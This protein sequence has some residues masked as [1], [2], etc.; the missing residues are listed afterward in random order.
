[1]SLYLRTIAT[2]T[3]FNRQVKNESNGKI[4][5][6][7]QEADLC[8]P[9]LKRQKCGCVDFQELPILSG[10]NCWCNTEII[11]EYV[12]RIRFQ[13]VTLGD[14]EVTGWKAESE[15]GHCLWIPDLLRFCVVST[16]RA[17]T[18]PVLEK[19]LGLDVGCWCQILNVMIK[20]WTRKG[21]VS[22][23]ADASYPL[24]LNIRCEAEVRMLQVSQQR[25]L[26]SRENVRLSGNPQRACDWWFWCVDRK[27]SNKEPSGGDVGTERKHNW[28]HVATKRK[29]VRRSR[30]AQKLQNTPQPWTCRLYRKHLKQTGRVEVLTRIKQFNIWRTDFLWVER[31]CSGHSPGN[32]CC[33]HFPV[34][35][36][37]VQSCAFEVSR[38]ALWNASCSSVMAELYKLCAQ[39]TARPLTF[40][41]DCAGSGGLAASQLKVNAHFI[42]HVSISPRKVHAQR[43]NPADREMPFLCGQC[44][45]NARHSTRWLIM[46]YPRIL[47][48]CLY[49]TGGL[50]TPWHPKT[51]LTL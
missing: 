24:R 35:D 29:G 28:N 51:H 32:A 46:F 7:M 27:N 20:T 19:P 22:V 31:K 15:E 16:R 21:D 10:R 50:I 37:T 26:R 6:P 44:F 41:N 17:Q 3:P 14:Q 36:H 30:G 38:C 34:G 43:P 49:P 40:E 4:F 33:L 13:H 1:M 18:L 11:R 8:A 25:V 47:G 45:L 39:P 23:I 5:D 12:A 48:V 2:A 9:E 42:T